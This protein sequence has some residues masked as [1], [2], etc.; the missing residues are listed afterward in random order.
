MKKEYNEDHP[1]V[2]GLA[3]KAATGKTAVAE[4]IVPKASFGNVNSGL[5]WDHI[6]FAM[7]L[8][9]FYSIRSVIEGQNAQS[10]KL[11]SIH[12]A[13]YD[14]YGNSPLGNMP[15]Y[16]DFISLVHKINNEKLDFD[17]SKP[18]SFL[19]KVGDYCREYDEA[20]FAKWGTRKAS[21]IHNEYLFNLDPSE[22]E[23]PHCVII[24]DVRFLNEAQAILNQP[25]GM[26]IKFDASDEVR[27]QRIFNR[28]SVFMTDEQLSHRSEKEIDMMSDMIDLVI[29]SSEIKIEEQVNL[30]I[31]AVK[32]SFGL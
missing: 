31:K 3:G 6:F 32:E 28:D 24:S 14:L 18:R 17:G 2:L 12:S 1:I 7:P 22:E 23:S 13:L 5:V 9:E 26:I 8:Y 4:S 10:R 21:S 16:D 25:N 19:Q 30:T 11:F 27:R 20:C 15:A 29:D